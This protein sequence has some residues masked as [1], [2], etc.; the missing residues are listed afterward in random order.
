MWSY[1]NRNGK[2]NW[3]EQYN[4]LSGLI[5]GFFLA[6]LYFSTKARWEDNLTAKSWRRHGIRPRLVKVPMQFY[7]IGALVF[8]FAQFNKAPVFSMK[9]RWRNWNSRFIRIL[10]YTKSVIRNHHAAKGESRDCLFRGK[11]MW[12]TR[13][14]QRFSLNTLRTLQHTM[15]TAWGRK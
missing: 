12:R 1:R 5:G 11:R 9:Y 3:S 14:G 2:F 4:L 6:L 10:F 15:Q 8:T 7:F 13:I